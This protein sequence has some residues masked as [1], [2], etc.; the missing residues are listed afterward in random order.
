MAMIKSLRT[1]V[2]HQYRTRFTVTAIIFPLFPLIIMIIRILKQSAQTLLPFFN[3]PLKMQN[4]YN[5]KKKLLKVN[6]SHSDTLALVLR[7]Q[8]R[9]LALKKSICLLS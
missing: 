1:T 6:H 3:G 8:L 5:L 2:L 9:D 4:T 7:K